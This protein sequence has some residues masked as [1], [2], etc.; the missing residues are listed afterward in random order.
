M[1][2]SV[3]QIKDK[4]VFTY[5]DTDGKLHIKED[6]KLVLIKEFQ[7]CLYQRHYNKLAEKL[8]KSI[9]PQIDIVFLEKG[10]C[11]EER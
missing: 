4:G 5:E 1:T 2:Y 3:D 7:R 9:D 6:D 11:F 10:L 8:K